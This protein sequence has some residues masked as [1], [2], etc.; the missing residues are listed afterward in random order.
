[1]QKYGV[2]YST[3]EESPYGYDDFKF[4][5]VIAFDEE[6]ECIKAAMRMRELAAPA[7]PFRNIGLQRE[8]NWRFVKE[9]E[10]LV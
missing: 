8:V 1:M 4:P 10:I 3:Y 9:N 7:I 6:D 2:A 5:L